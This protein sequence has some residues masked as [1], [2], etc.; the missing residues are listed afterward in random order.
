[1]KLTWGFYIESVPFTPAVVAGTASLGG[2]ESACLGLARALRARDQEVHI[3]ATQLDPACVGVDS[4]GVTWHQAD[5]LVELGTIIDWDVFVVLRM[6]PAWPQFPI[7]ARLKVLW[8]QDLYGPHWQQLMSAAWAWDRLVYVSEY[9]R[10]QWETLEPNLRGHSWVT[11]NGF[12]PA[13]VPKGVRKVPGRIIHISRPERGLAPLLAMWPALRQ[14]HPEA[15]LHLARYSSM[16][17][18]QGWGQVC[19]DFDRQVEKVNAQVGGITY[20]GELGKADL[21]RAIA[22]AA[23]MWYPG[24]PDFAETS[25]IAAIE[26]Q[27]CGTPLV[28][29]YK[30]AL[31]ETAP[32]AR[33]VPGDAFTPEYQER[34]VRLVGEL[35]DGCARNTRDYREL[36]RL[37]RAHAKGYSFTAVAA[38]W[39]TW[40]E[41]EF[42]Q[43]FAREAPAILREL[44]HF[45]DHAAAL[46]LAKTLPGPEAAAAV[47]MC[48]RVMAGLEQTA[49]DYGERAVADPLVEMRTH[50]AGVWGGNRVQIAGEYLK[51]C[52]TVLDVA[53]GNGSIALYLAQTYPTMRITGLDYAAKNIA[54]AREA[55]ARL[56]VSDRV[57]FHQ[58]TVWDLVRQVPGDPLP[59]GPYD[60]MFVGEFLE[61]VADA[62][63]LI[64]YLERQV[65][66]GG[67]VVY[68][69]PHGPLCELVPRDLPHLRGHVHH[70]QHRDLSQVFGLKKDVR[71]HYS[72][73]GVTPRARPCGTWIVR[74]TAGEGGAARPRDLW[75]VILTTRPAVR[76]SVG[77]ITLDASK[78]LARCLDSV[79]DVADEI[80]IGDTG[81]RDDTKAIAQ[82]YA[83]KV[84]VVDL[85]SI[86]DTREGFAGARNAVLGECV[87]EWFLWI[88]ADEVLTHAVG[89][90]Q[91]LQGPWFN[92]LAIHQVHLQMDVPGGYDTPVR[93][94]R[95]DP[96]IRFYGCVHEQPGQHDANTDIMP[97]LELTDVQIA[98]FGYL[99]D[100]VRKGKMLTRNLPLLN[101]DQE[102]FPDRRLG[103]VLVLR[104]LVNLAEYE[105]GHGGNAEVVLRYLRE[106]VRVYEKHFADPADKYHDLGRPFYEAAIKALG[107]MELE[108]SL[109][110]QVGGLNGKRATPKRLW[111]RDTADLKRHLKW[112]VDRIEKQ[113]QPPNLHTDPFDLGGTA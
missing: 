7:V 111:V 91:Y 59:A 106:A 94:F 40:A 12:D 82:R 47:T 75:P 85:P 67:L 33:F 104:D 92:G 26:A 57:Q 43:R 18:A 14:A 5:E 56:G 58:V 21:Y 4:S 65:R 34:S 35:L 99:T 32:H 63:G 103:K 86:V 8:N 19:A 6:W 11:R 48:E 36:Q 31:P 52:G 46:A 72:P 100:D 62:P 10:Q 45:D 1:M 69:V 68:T 15:T 71:L 37:G 27:A 107:G 24:V 54:H 98:H 28:L 50:A 9:H 93:V 25:C 110:G 16:Y 87:G 2:S 90:H 78:D 13:L 74:Y 97:T 109:G 41:G 88:D 22:T 70:F 44:L 49:E 38:D 95:R 20:L 81:S 77:M 61:H 3:F 51:D 64:D 39:Q 79:W 42:Q 66:P 101:R 113:L 53:C 60:G 80:V 76:L 105:R 96:S 89:L 30:G 73:W 108:Y 102:V 112:E 29:S 84:R 17:D 83:R 23:V 55:A